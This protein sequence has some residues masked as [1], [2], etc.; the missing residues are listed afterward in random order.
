MV[1]TFGEAYLV[2][3]DSG[4]PGGDFGVVLRPDH[5]SRFGS[6]S[7]RARPLSARA[8]ENLT[9]IRVIRAYGQ[10]EPQIAV[11]MRESRLRCRNIQLI[12][13]GATSSPRFRL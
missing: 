9:G 6:D 12:G 10:E 3:A 13:A 8:Q 7:G 1:E 11:S 2:G 4:T 5:S